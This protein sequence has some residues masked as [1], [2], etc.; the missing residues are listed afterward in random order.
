MKSK[1]SRNTSLVSNTLRNTLKR[2]AL[3]AVLITACGYPGELNAEEFHTR[4]TCTLHT[5]LAGTVTVEA[6]NAINC[7]DVQRNFDLAKRMFDAAAEA[8]HLATFEE[9]F[10]TIHIKIWNRQVLMCDQWAVGACVHFIKGRFHRNGAV[11]EI[12][13]NNGGELLLHELFHG[14]I[15]D[16]EHQTW[17]RRG[18]SISDYIFRCSALLYTEGM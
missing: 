10:T 1:F 17:Q 14:L 5:E 18:F 11:S 9:K 2:A 15:N 4:T 8:D 12:D 7:A 13:L 16:P 3:S 6:E